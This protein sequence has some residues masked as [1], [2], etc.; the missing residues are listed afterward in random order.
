MAPKEYTFSDV[1]S[2]KSRDDL[3]VVIQGK[4]KPLDVT[5]SVWVT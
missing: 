4:G 2:H 3:W 1:A 5:I